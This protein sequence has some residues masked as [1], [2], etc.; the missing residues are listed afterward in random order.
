MSENYFA[1]NYQRKIREDI[2]YYWKSL[3]QERNKIFIK[4]SKFFSSI[5]FT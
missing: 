5:Y 1:K 3:E 2:I 4:I